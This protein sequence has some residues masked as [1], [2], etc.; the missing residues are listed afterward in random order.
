MDWIPKALNLVISRV[1]TN[2]WG[3]SCPS[4][5]FVSGEPSILAAFTCGFLSGILFGIIL[6][7][8]FLGLLPL[9]S[10]AS[11]LL[12]SP[13]IQQLLGFVP[14][15]M[16][17]EPSSDSQDYEEISLA[18]SFQGLSTSV[19]GPAHRTLDFVH[20]LLPDYQANQ[21]PASQAPSSACGC[22]CAFC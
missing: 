12:R 3:L 11:P 18:V 8:W 19:V 14:T 15:L 21:A 20:R 6:L 2:W 16:S 5:C 17:Q 10:Q 7:A 1:N 4:H 9:R 13:A 22:L